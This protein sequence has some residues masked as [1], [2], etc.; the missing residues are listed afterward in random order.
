[1]VAD[2][3]KVLGEH[4]D[5]ARLIVERVGTPAACAHCTSLDVVRFGFADEQQ[6]MRCKTC[7][8][9]FTALSNTPCLR[10]RDKEKLLVHAECM[11]SGMTIRA[12]AEVVGLTVDRAFRWRHRFLALLAEQQPS[13]MTGIVEADETFFRRAYKGQRRGIPRMVKKRGGPSPD[14]T[15]NERV[16]VM[17]AL[18]RGA[19]ITT[20]HMLANLSS[21]LSIQAA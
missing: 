8:K 18:Q 21:A 16:P 9:T 10:L 7:G 20:D 4:A 15:D 2:R 11:S 6:R 12:T 17:V 1:V 3:V 14:A 19:R 5:S 13:G